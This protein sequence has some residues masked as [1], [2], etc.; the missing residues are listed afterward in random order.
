[1]R[2]SPNIY[3][4]CVECPSWI[5]DLQQEE[6]FEI[7]GDKEKYSEAIKFFESC[8]NAIYVCFKNS[9]QFSKY[10]ISEYNEVLYE[11]GTSN[12]YKYITIT[13]S[14]INIDNQGSQQAGRYQTLTLRL[15]K[16]DNESSV[17]HSQVYCDYFY[18]V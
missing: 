7:Y 17:N 12:E 1:M 2:R 6:N 18:E 15:Y 16:N 13:Y 10:I 4:S 9:S 8:K 11:E 3:N 14:Y 5:S